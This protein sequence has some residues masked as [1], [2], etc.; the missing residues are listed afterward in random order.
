LDLRTNNDYFPIQRQ[1]VGFHNRDGECLQRG[2]NWSSNQTNYFLS[3][4]Y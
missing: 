2:T 4:K 1:L 3:L